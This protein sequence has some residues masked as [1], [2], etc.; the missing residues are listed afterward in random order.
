MK[1]HGTLGPSR[2]SM[3][4]LA[5]EAGVQRST[6]YRH[7]PDDD[8]V[9]AACSAHWTARNPAPEP[10]DWMALDDPDARLRRA[11][12]LL[13]GYYGRTEGM[14]SNLV[15]DEP[16]MPLVAHTF[17]PFRTYVADIQDGL[18]RDRRLRGARRRR[19]RAAIGHAID[20]TTWRSLVRE[21]GLA[22]ADAVT[23]M[24]E[25]VRAA[26]APTRPL[27]PSSARRSP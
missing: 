3:S 26:E 8:A 11:L 24:C 20:F 15:R 6:L 16:L 5:Q 13:Y 7:F 1:L 2:T 22:D 17:R 25:L 18:V 12:E 23:L 4:A 9:F 10:G 21:H 19:A 27:R 14:L